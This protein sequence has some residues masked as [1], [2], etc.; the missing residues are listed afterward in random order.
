MQING[1]S[2]SGRILTITGAR[3][4][5][6]GMDVLNSIFLM[7]EAINAVFIN[8]INDIFQSV[9]CLPVCS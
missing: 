6:C 4:I 5:F 7:Q 8:F 9:E 2:V 3:D 1:I